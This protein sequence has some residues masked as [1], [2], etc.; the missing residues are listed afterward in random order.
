MKLWT[1]DTEAIMTPNLMDGRFG[2]LAPAVGASSGEV[3][4]ECVRCGAHLLAAPGLRGE[5][6]GVCLVCGAE[7]FT[8]VSR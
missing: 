3:R 8:P 6:F 7:N 5:L 4:C 2:R 1:T